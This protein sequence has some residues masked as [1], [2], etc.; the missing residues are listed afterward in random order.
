M[1][2]SPDGRAAPRD[3]GRRRFLTKS[4]ATGGALATAGLV[5]ARAMAQAAPDPLIT[6]VQPWA[7][8]LGDGVDAFPYGIRSSSRMM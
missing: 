6:E 4:M 5:P 1:T 3:A 7:S 2:D 8:Y